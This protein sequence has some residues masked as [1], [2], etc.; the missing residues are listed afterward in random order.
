[1]SESIKMKCE[2]CDNVYVLSKT[3]ELLKETKSMTCNWCPACEDN[4]T[5]DYKESQHYNEIFGAP[6]PNQIKLEL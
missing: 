2:S 3:S 1:M 5:E 6:D 4:A